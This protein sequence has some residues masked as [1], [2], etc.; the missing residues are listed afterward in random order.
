MSAKRR[1]F[2][3]RT[4]L[5]VLLVVIIIL[6]IAVFVMSAEDSDQTEFTVSQITN[7]I[8][9]YIGDRITVVGIYDSTYGDDG[10]LKPPTFDT[11]IAPQGN[12]LL[13]LSIDDETFNETLVSGVKYR[14][15]GVLE[16]IDSPLATEYGIT[17][18][19]ELIV[20]TAEQV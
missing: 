17:Y 9:K 20:E 1:N 10:S 8:K 16:E 12:E 2:D 3:T 15:T 14:V 6:A 18:G 5:Y 19:V 7:N 4:V 13:P 11:Q